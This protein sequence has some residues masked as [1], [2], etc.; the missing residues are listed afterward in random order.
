MIENQKNMKCTLTNFSD[1]E[2]NKNRAIC[3]KKK[4]WEVEIKSLCGSQLNAGPSRP[5]KLKKDYHSSRPACVQNKSLCQK[6]KGG[7]FCLGFG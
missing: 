4:K 5:G 1:T 3:L 6:K 7:C 2:K